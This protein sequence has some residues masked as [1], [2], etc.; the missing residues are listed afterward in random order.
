MDDAKRT[1]VGEAIG[2][3]VSGVSILTAGEGDAGTGVLVSWVQQVSF[4]PPMVMVAVKKG[5]PIEKLIEASGKFAVSVLAE[6][7]NDLMRHFSRGY[8]PG[9]DAFDG[10][11]TTVRATGTPVLG[12]ALAFMDCELSTTCQAGDHNLYIG[13]VVD[14]AMLGSA[15]RPM[16]HIRKTG[17][18]Y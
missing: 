6:D 10:V 18:S 11:A 4:D 3:I 17:F 16:V 2:K 9:Q 12:D 5:R 13:Q 14:G 15:G 8:E 7:D 1:A